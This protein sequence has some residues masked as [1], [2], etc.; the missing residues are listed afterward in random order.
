MIAGLAFAAAV[1]ESEKLLRHAQTAL[2]FDDLNTAVG[3][4]KESIALLLPH[5]K[6]SHV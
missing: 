6:A 4:L 2:R 3:K 5:L 1:S